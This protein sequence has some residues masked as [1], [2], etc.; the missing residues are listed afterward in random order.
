[1]AKHIVL[2]GGGIMSATI[3]TILEQL[4]SDYTFTIIERL[5]KVAEESSE[6]WNNAGT[7]HNAYCELNYTPQLEDESIDVSKAI[8]IAH[9][10]EMSKCFWKY[11]VDEKII[12]NPN[13]FIRQTPHYSFV[14]GNDDVAYLKKRFELLQAHPLFAEME[15]T[16]DPKTVCNWLPL[17]ME[18]R[19]TTIPFAATKMDAGTDVDFGTLTD[20]LIAYLAGQPNVN[21]LLNTEVRDAEQLVDGNWRVYCKNLESNESHYID[22]DFVFVGAGGGTLPILEKA[23]IKE[24]EGF[25]GFPVGGQ[26]LIC[27][28]EKFINKHHAKV[29]GKAKIGAPPMSVPHVDSRIINGKR[30]LLFGPFA[31]FSTKFLKNG[32]YFDLPLSIELHNILPMLQ[33]GYHNMALTKYL[34]EQVSLTHEERMESLREFVPTARNEDWQ[35]AEAG[36]RVQVIKKDKE[37][38][39]VLEFGTEII[40]TADGTWSALLGASPGASTA[41]YIVLQILEKCFPQQYKKEWQT[42]LHQMI[43]VLAIGMNKNPEQWAGIRDENNRVL[44]NRVV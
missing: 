30:E 28:N 23:N 10:F 16:T 19:D 38:G 40:T 9:S 29:Y 22:A 7:G 14:W 8:K 42:K 24:A 41:V 13:T 43:P 3:G 5:P 11:I 20:E 25:G 27:R 31:S 18:Q 37:Q 44:L 35:L 26:W 1:M 15:F 32:S 6:A 34:I 39:G 21:L 4:S 17:I 36:Q 33:A 12:K 2:I